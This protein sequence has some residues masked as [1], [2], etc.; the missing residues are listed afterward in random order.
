ML[1]L[2]FLA[3]Q[4]RHVPVNLFAKFYLFRSALGCN[5]GSTDNPGNNQKNRAFKRVGRPRKKAL[6]MKGTRLEK[7]P[8]NLKR[9]WNTRDSKEGDLQRSCSRITRKDRKRKACYGQ[10]GKEKKDEDEVRKEFA[11]SDSAEVTQ[12]LLRGAA[13]AEEL[14]EGV[15][16][17]VI[18]QVSRE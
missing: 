5:R 2:T 13:K 4:L 10:L 8:A 7:D 9:E 15:D 16:N 11:A 17:A 12:C 6:L 18:P 1:C 3:A 14:C